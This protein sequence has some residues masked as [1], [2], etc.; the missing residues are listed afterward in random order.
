MRHSILSVILSG[1]IIGA[2]FFFM[3]KLVLG[4]FIFLVI[5]RLLHCGHMA[6]RGYYRGYYGHHGYGGG[7]ECGYDYRDGSEC[8]EM[9]QGKDRDSHH[10]H[11]HGHH[12]G[13][14]SKHGSM[15]EWA[16]KIRN[17]SEEEY[18]VFKDNMKKGFG[19]GYPGGRSYN[20][21]RCECGKKRKEDCNCDTKTPNQ[22][23]TQQTESK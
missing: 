8:C 21:D 1:I 17:M 15:N 7:C 20:D 18:S 19:H 11:H 23:T 13:H 3:P 16:D 10:H 14:G 22:D 9:E 2:L 6:H 5:I 4:I 12:Y